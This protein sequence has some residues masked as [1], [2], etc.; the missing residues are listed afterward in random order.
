MKKIVLLAAAVIALAGC[1]SKQN[2]YTIKGENVTVES[3]TVYL[4]DNEG[5]TVTTAEVVDGA[6]EIQGSVECPGIYFLADGQGEDAS[7]GAQ[8]ILEPGVIVIA[9]DPENPNT[10]S[11][12][13]TPANDAA[14]AFNREAQNLVAEYRAPETTEERRAEIEVLF[15]EMAPKAIADNRNNFFSV[16]LLAQSVG[17]MS[18]DEILAE[19]EQIAPELQQCELAGRIRDIAEAKSKVAVGKPY[20][21]LEFNDTAD[22]PVSLKSVVENPDNKYVLLDFWASWCGPCMAEMPHLKACYEEYHKKGFEIYG[23]SLDN[24]K[25]AWVK[26]IDNNK[27]AWVNVSSLAGWED[28]GAAEYAVRSIPSN[29]LIDCSTGEIVALNLRGEELQ[30]KVGELLK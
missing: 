20:I 30:E 29:F 27:M 18:G 23:V 13:G 17:E 10:K 22:A 16:I 7:L 25:D 5:N 2:S 11:V 1:T 19:L 4:L 6:F 9:D 12:A 15:E 24:N 21:N 26:A 8:L 28:A 14:A 3:G